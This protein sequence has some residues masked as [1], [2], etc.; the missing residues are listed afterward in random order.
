MKS[1]K[2]F[3]LTTLVLFS[4]SGFTQKTNDKV[5]FRDST[6][7]AIDMS[8]WLLNKKGFLVYPTII[9]EPAVGYGGAGAAI[10][11]HSSYND[12]KAPPSMSGVFGMGTANGTWGAGIF[13]VGYWKKDRIR[14]MGTV[15]RMNVNVEFYGSGNNGLLNIESV[16]MNMDS[17]FLLQQL[18]FRIAESNFFAGGKY[19][20][21]NTSNTFDIPIDIPEFDGI[22]LKSTL[23]EA[24]AILNFDTRNNIFS[25]TKGFYFELSGTYSDTWMGG[26]DLYGRLTTRE[27]GYIPAT[28]NIMVGV[29]NE[30]TFSFGDVPFYVR[31][32]VILRGAP[33]MKYQNKNTTVTEVQVDWN[34]Y[35]RWNLVGFTGIGNAFASFGEFNEGKSV[36]NIG[37][38]FRYLLARKF[39]MQMGMDFAQS[40][41]DFAFYF[42]FGTSWMR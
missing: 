21:F 12:R 25:P 28:N 30:N 22:H 16:N 6:D 4:F 18:K 13:H 35:R 39:G 33:L 37:T 40:T 8:D 23:S 41:D 42:V 17:W 26:D 2:I 38:G 19:I 27:I 9:T 1:L 3:L 24:T 10:Y 5:S 32:I 7:N 29:R 14:Y 36:A 11:F 31:P 15:G 20:F 34:F